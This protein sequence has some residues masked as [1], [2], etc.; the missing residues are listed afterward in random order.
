MQN[1][2]II[3]AARLAL[4]AAQ[5]MS[6]ETYEEAHAALLAAE[7]AAMSADPWV[8]GIDV[9]HVATRIRVAQLGGSWREAREVAERALEFA[10]WRDDGKNPLDA[11]V[12]AH[13]RALVAAASWAAEVRHHCGLGLAELERTA[14]W[15]EVPVGAIVAR[16]ETEECVTLLCANGVE[17]ARHG[18][19]EDW[20]LLHYSQK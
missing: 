19:E 15:D 13:A 8:P 3:N 9:N 5:A 1:E 16:Y 17:E 4:R 11:A 2:N 14:V 18:V 20:C 12:A 7:Q 6:D 10:R